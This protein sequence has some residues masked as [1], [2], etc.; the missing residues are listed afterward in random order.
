[1]SFKSYISIDFSL[2]DDFYEWEDDAQEKYWN[3]VYS[4]QADAEEAYCKVIDKKLKKLGCEDIDV[5]I[6][7]K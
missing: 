1:M 4:V 2:P 7:S 3:N 6:E 5:D